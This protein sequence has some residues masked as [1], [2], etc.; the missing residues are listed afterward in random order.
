MAKGPRRIPSG[1]AWIASIFTSQQARSYGVARRAR[2]D[3][4]KHAS[5]SAL[6]M[7][8]KRRGFHMIRSGDQYIILCHRG[9]VRIIC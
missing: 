5:F 8:V 6:R 7:E 4:K 9:D 2:A 3:V 1:S